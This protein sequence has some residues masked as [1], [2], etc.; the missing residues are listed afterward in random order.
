MR[1][2]GWTE[3]IRSADTIIDGERLKR[4]S[5]ATLIKFYPVVTN[6]S[7]LTSVSNGTLRKKRGE[8]KVSRSLREKSFYKKTEPT[9]KVAVDPLIVDSIASR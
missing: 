3:R 6:R 4:A 5:L 1:K 7:V 9:V 2:F 8:K